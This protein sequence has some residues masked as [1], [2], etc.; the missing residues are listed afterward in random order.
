MWITLNPDYAQILP[1]RFGNVRNSVYICTMEEKQNLSKTAPKKLTFPQVK[2][3]YE[4][5]FNALYGFKPL[6][7]Q[8]ANGWISMV[9]TEFGIETKFRLAELNNASIT[10]EGR[11]IQPILAKKSNDPTTHTMSGGLS[12]T[13]GFTEQ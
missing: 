11:K 9:T 8:Y 3:R 2:E 4:N 6:R 12:E 1:Q 7:I 13:F 5:A 10:L